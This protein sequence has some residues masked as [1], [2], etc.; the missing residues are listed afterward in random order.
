MTADLARIVAELQAALRLH[1]QCGQITLNLNEGEVQSVEVHTKMRIVER[2]RADFPAAGDE[3]R[4][5]A[6]TVVV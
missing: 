6:S 5:T 4:L 2:R 1:V 3:R